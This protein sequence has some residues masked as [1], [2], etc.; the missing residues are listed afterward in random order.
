MFLSV[1]VGTA[2][3]L[4]GGYFGGVADEMV[5]RMLDAI[6]AFPTILLYLIIISAIGPSAVNVV[7]AITFVGAPGV[8]RLVRSLTLDIRTRD[9][10]R[11]AETRGESSLYIMFVEILP[12]ARGPL[13]IDAMLRVGYAIFAIGTLGFLGLGL[14]PPTPD[15]GGMINEARKLHLDQPAGRPVAGAGHRQPGGGAEPASPTACA[16][17]SD[18]GTRMDGQGRRLPGPCPCSVFPIPRSLVPR[19][20][21][22]M[23]PDYRPHTPILDVRDLAISYETRQGDVPAVRGVSFDIQRGETLGIVG[24]SGCGKSTVA[25]GIVNFLGRNGKIVKGNILFQG[26]DLVGRSEEELR[27][28]R[29]DRIAMVYQDPMQALNPSMRIGDQIVRG[30]DR[31]PGHEQSGRG[32]Q[33]HPDAGARLHARSGQRHAALPAPDLRRAAAARRDRHGAAQRPGAADHGRADDRP[34]RDGRGGGARPDRRPAEG[35]RHGHHVHQPQPGRGRARVRPGGRDVCR[36]DGRAGPGGRHLPPA[37]S[38]LHAGADALRAPA[39]R[40]T[41]RAAYLY[42]IPGRVPSPK[43]LPPGCIFEPRCD[44]ARPACRQ[45]RPELREV[46]A[47]HWVRCLFAEEIVGKAWTS[48]RRPVHRRHAAS[49]RRPRRTSR[50]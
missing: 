15:W 29:G 1:L 6:M 35:F 47:G 2:L 14:P 4:F 41:R 46:V 48:A 49:R 44:F 43:S 21:Q 3:G 24:E 20:R 12:N 10:I 9:Y 27:K 36:R 32:S 19:G 5:M 40:R 8:A 23:I 45:E 17:K 26:Q 37:P 28:I 34:G 16:K 25:F 7:M 11:A 31:P 22:G 50:S 18:D 30:A 42:P 33:V 13:I 39:G 38:S